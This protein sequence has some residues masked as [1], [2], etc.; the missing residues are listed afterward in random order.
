[1]EEAELINEVSGFSDAQ[2][3]SRQSSL[4]EVNLVHFFTLQRKLH[5]RMMQQRLTV[6]YIHRFVAVND[7]VGTSASGGE[8]DTRS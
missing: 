6:Y 5:M 2:V 3:I 7:R 4:C 1:M 8:N